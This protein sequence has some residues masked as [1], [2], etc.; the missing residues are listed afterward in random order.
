MIKVSSLEMILENDD[1][2]INMT[3]FNIIFSKIILKMQHF[4][5]RFRL[6][7]VFNID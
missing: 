6:N 1:V 3:K 4:F 5:I 2:E 7:E